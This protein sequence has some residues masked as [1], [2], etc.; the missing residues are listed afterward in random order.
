MSKL[1]DVVEETL[2]SYSDKSTINVMMFGIDEETKQIIDDYPSTHVVT[3]D[4]MSHYP[5]GFVDIIICAHNVTQEEMDDISD[6]VKTQFS[7]TVIIEESEGD[8]LSNK[9]KVSIHQIKYEHF[10]YLDDNAPNIIVYSQTADIT[11]S[12][13]S[14]LSVFRSYTGDYVSGV[15]IQSAPLTNVPFTIVGGAPPLIESDDFDEDLFDF[16]NRGG[17]N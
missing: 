10:T 16:D 17:D 5:W 12:I 4:N 13:G 8:K 15:S 7:E 6:L 9:D 2:M 1:H 11:S 14:F 3:I